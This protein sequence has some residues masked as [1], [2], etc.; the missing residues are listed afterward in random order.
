MKKIILSLILI[1]TLLFVSV[2]LVGNTYGSPA[3]GQTGGVRGWTHEKCANGREVWD[4]RNCGDSPKK[5]REPPTPQPTPAPPAAIQ[6]VP[7]ANPQW[8]SVLGYSSSFNQCKNLC[9]QYQ[10]N[11]C[12]SQIATQYCSQLLSIDLNRNGNINA[13]ENGK[14]PSGTLD[15]ETNAKCYDVIPD[16]QCGGQSLNLGSCVN[17][18]YSTYIRSGL[19]SAQALSNVALTVAGSCKPAAT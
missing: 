7:Q 18:F 4:C 10:Q 3:N 1:F 12:D 5:E 14:G 19:N 15:C 2:K 6:S 9:V 8:T 17:L 13:A 11:N 16:C